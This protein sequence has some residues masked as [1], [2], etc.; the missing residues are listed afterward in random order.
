M[1][2]VPPCDIS[3]HSLVFALL[4]GY[5]GSSIRRLIRAGLVEESRPGGFCRNN[6]RLLRSL[7]HVH[8]RFSGFYGFA[9]VRIAIDG[10]QR[11]GRLTQLFDLIHLSFSSVAPLLFTHYRTD[12][13]QALIKA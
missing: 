9:A 13:N 11:I 3:P 2:L 5:G 10:F 12:K 6:V 1:L 8:E 7:T 4:W